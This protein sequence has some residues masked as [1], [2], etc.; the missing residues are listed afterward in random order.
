[1]TAACGPAASP[2]ASTATGATQTTSVRPAPTVA[3]Q[4]TPTSAQSVPTSP[5]IGAMQEVR[6]GMAYIPNVQFAPFYVAD[7]KGYFAAEGI[8][9]VYDYGFEQ[10]VLALTAED[11][12]TF[13]NAGASA[14]IAARARGVPI[15]YFIEEYLSMPIAIFAPK[16][17]GITTIADLKGRSVGQPGTFGETY[18][19]LKIMLDKV[20]LAPSDV[21][22]VNIGFTQVTAL[23]RHK[24]DAAIG[25]S[26][27]EPLQLRAQGK[28]VVQ[29]DLKDFAPE[30]AGNGI[31]ASEKTLRE[32][33]ELARAFA[34]AF[35]KGLDDTISNPQEAFEISLK[36]VPDAAKDVATR[37][38]QFQVLKLVVDDYLT[39][40][41]PLGRSDVKLWERTQSIMKA[42]GLIERETDM[43]EAVT[44]AYLPS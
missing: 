31:I 39:T 24:V 12:L 22:L 1:M 15:Q 28:E 43:H 23:L 25:Y 21:H 27:N 40:T 6:V 37:E 4:L 3:S 26:V 38:A 13:T 9:P 34:R 36:F 29:F 20:G 33:P 10:D 5:S 30:V 2:P 32:N 8:K 18:A 35:L 17:S 19:G 44:N 41:E 7:A 14:V 16:E 42:T 11:K